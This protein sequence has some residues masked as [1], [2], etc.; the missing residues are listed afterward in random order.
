MDVGNNL[1]RAQPKTP[2]THGDTPVV[3]R[4]YKFDAEAPGNRG[5]EI[6]GANCNVTSV[7]F[8]AAVRTPVSLTVPL[9]GISTPTLTVMCAKPGM[10]SGSLVVSPFNKTTTDMISAG[11]SAGLA[12]LL[13]MGVIAAAS[14]P[15][16]HQYVYPIQI[17]I[18]LKPQ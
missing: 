5:E 1:V 2:P 16:Q 14:D 15:S 4:A 11:S 10:G 6:A 17:W 7:H 3:I 12:G 8:S 13:L 9:Y 18:T